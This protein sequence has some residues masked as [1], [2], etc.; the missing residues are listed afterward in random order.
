MQ[1]SQLEVKS[2]K[3]HYFKRLVETYRISV[4]R[5]TVGFGR[6]TAQIAEVHQE[7][8]TIRSSQNVKPTK[9]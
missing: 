8:R 7:G 2:V 3:A 4:D 9:Y 6:R 5:V 1:Q